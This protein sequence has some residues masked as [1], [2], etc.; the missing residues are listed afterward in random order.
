MRS[1]PDTHFFGSPVTTTLIALG[2][3]NQVSPALM[4]AAMSVDPTP[5]ENA[6]T[7]P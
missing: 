5:V 3:L 7:Q 1:L 2:T 4:P 6:P